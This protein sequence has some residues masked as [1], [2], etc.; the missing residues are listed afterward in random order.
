MSKLDCEHDFKGPKHQPVRMFCNNCGAP[1][2]LVDEIE[3]LTARVTSLEEGYIQNEHEIEQLLGKA[4]GYPWYKDD[5]KNF[6]DATELDGVCV[7]EHSALT[8]A[9]EAA[10]RF[11]EIREAVRRL[12]SLQ[13]E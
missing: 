8:L 3:R 12:G 2:E 7:G 6:P 13:P 10:T 9:M 5:P 1:K 4:L 11:Q